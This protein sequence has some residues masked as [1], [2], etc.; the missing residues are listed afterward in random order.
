MIERQ[1][2]IYVDKK[3]IYNLKVSNGIRYIFEEAMM[4]LHERERN[5]NRPIDWHKMDWR[6]AEMK[7]MA[8]IA[9]DSVGSEISVPSKVHGQFRTQL[10]EALKVVRNRIKNKN[11]YYNRTEDLIR[12]VNGERGSFRTLTPNYIP[13]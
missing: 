5:P 13:S 1:E 10:D 2:S 12:S 6:I 7:P 9:L 4:I 3:I 11:I 8:E